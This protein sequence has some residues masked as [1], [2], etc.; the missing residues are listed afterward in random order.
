MVTDSWIVFQQGRLQNTSL[1]TSNLP[2]KIKQDEITEAVVERV[3][4]QTMRYANGTHNEPIKA[5]SYMMKFALI[6]FTIPRI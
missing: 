5:Q 4:S 6:L 1:H 3:H 2:N